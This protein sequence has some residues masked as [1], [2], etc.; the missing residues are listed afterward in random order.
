[1]GLFGSSPLYSIVPHPFTEERIKKL[2]TIAHIPYLKESEE[3]LIQQ[4][5]ISRRHADG[6]IS[7][8]HIYEALKELKNQNKISL[9]LRDKTMAV[10]KTYFDEQFPTA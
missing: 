9:I 4:T 8:Q 5:I 2:I 6:T 1:M 3:A 7:L 10:I